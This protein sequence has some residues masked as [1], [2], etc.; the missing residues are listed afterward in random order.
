MIFYDTQLLQLLCN[1]ITII[2]SIFFIH[3]ICLDAFCHLTHTHKKTLGLRF[4]LT[5]LFSITLALAMQN[6]QWNLMSFFARLS[7][8]AQCKRNLT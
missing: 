3:T 7:L 5:E 2:T 1:S 8:R 6:F 4:R